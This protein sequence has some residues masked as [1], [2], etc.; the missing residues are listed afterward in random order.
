[1]QEIESLMMLNLYK[2][3]KLNE[4]KLENVMKKYDLRKIDMDIIKR[5]YYCFSG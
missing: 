4:R 5:V 2:F 3:R 1:M